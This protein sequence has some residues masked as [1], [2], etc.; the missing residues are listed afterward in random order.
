M[1]VMYAFS[2]GLYTLILSSKACV[3]STEV[4]CFARILFETS[5]KDSDNNSSDAAAV[6]ESD[7]VEPE[8][9][10]RAVTPSPIATNS[11]RLNLIPS[12]YSFRIEKLSIRSRSIQDFL[13]RNNLTRF[14]NR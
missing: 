14:R 10:F 1:T 3:R 5:L 11:R 9:V 2:F 4:T 7:W 12:S 8:V 6:R 13:V